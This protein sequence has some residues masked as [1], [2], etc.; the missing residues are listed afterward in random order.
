MTPA[1]LLTYQV[2]GVQIHCVRCIAT[3][4]C[5]WLIDVDQPNE[6]YAVIDGDPLCVRHAYERSRSHE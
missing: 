5:G 1:D 3:V 4:A 6:A 2:N